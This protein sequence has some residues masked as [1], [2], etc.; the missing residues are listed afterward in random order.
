MAWHEEFYKGILPAAGQQP[1]QPPTEVMVPGGPAPWT[2]YGAGATIPDAYRLVPDAGNSATQAINAAAPASGA[3][4]GG[5]FPDLAAISDMA[6]PNGVARYKATMHPAILKAL[7]QNMGP[8][9][10]DKFSNAIAIGAMKR[11]T[12]G[13]GG[14][15]PLTF[16]GGNRVTVG[17]GVMVPPQSPGGG[18]AQ[19]SG[20]FQGSATGQNY[21]VGQ[22][23]AGTNGYFYQAMPDGTFKQIGKDPTYQSQQ[24]SETSAVNQAAFG[25]GTSP[26]PSG[27]WY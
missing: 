24:S 18:A 6:Y 23:Y 16:G 4:Y 13:R 14:P 7:S 19:Q 1:V 22:T 27:G 5:K 17:G 26:R 15:R 11:G 12:P 2:G 9:W 10:A 25:G 8:S 21:N 20:T 3:M